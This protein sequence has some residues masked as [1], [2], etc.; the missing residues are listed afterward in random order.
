MLF[1]KCKTYSPFS[2]FY[3]SW[4]HFA[5]LFHHLI[6]KVCVSSFFSE[7]FL[8]FE[9][10]TPDRDIEKGCIAALKAAK[11]RAFGRKR[12]RTLTEDKSASK[13]QQL[14]SSSDSDWLYIP[15]NFENCRNAVVHIT[16]W[17]LPRQ[18]TFLSVF[19][20]YTLWLIDKWFCFHVYWT[21]GS[22]CCSI[23]PYRHVWCTYIR[24]WDI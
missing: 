7:C 17:S 9:G 12:R 4:C 20:S 24:Q 10:G 5:S 3:I 11:D 6:F 15:F 2:P 19:A 8:K 21:V 16:A 23:G 13:Q 22:T 18:H 14:C 1:Y